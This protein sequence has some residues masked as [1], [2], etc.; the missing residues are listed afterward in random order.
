MVDVV[1]ENFKKDLDTVLFE[2][3]SA[4]IEKNRKYGDSVLSPVRVFSKSA[5]NEQIA[6]RLDDKL[7]RIVSSQSDEDEDVYQDI[8]GYLLIREIF[9]LREKEIQDAV[10]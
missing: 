9:K 5:I 3:R 4:L 10:K 1:Q 2:I 6:V 7:S 8:I